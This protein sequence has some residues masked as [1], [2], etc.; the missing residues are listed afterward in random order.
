MLSSLN[1][2]RRNVEEDFDKENA[3]KQL[4]KMSEIEKLDG[5]R[6]TKEADEQNNV[7]KTCLY[8]KSTGYKHMNRHFCSPECASKYYL[9][10]P[11]KNPYKPSG[12]KTKRRRTKKTKRRKGKTY[13][14]QQ[15]KRSKKR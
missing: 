1:L 3:S 12:G 10:Q 13:R 6:N 15:K 11:N 2:Q 7:P 9:L 8:C 14:K 5:L 4:D